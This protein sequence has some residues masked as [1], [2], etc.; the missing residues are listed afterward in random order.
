MINPDS[1]TDYNRCPA[2]LEEFLLF[3]VFVAGH[4]AHNTA[5][6]LDKFYSVLDVKA[7]TISIVPLLLNLSKSELKSILVQAKIGCYNKNVAFLK[8][9]AQSDIDLKTCSVTELEALKGV[10]PK[11]SRFFL[12]HSREDCQNFAVLDRHIL[13]FMKE[14]GL[15]VPSS[16]PNKKE[17]IKY[18]KMYLDL[19][20]KIN[21]N[22]SKAEI[23][24]AIWKSKRRKSNGTISTGTT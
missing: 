1:I 10:G 2:E 13:S 9:W 21:T 3:C 20:L 11:T 4:N 15:T 5:K 24:L 12:L 8:D 18:E 22:L 7:G 19:I 23:D 17:Y 16:T 6:A 14:H